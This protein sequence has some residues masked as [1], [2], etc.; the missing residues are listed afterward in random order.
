MRSQRGS[1]YQFGFNPPPQASK[2]VTRTRDAAE[3][4]ADRA[5]YEAN[6]AAERESERIYKEQLARA[7]YERDAIRAGYGRHLNF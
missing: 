5:R 4:V 7:L 6:Q 1:G 3:A 2:D